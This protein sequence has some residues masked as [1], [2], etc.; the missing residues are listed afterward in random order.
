MREG[1]RWLLKL[2][3]SRLK[4]ENLPLISLVTDLLMVGNV[5]DSLEGKAIQ[6]VKQ[7]IENSPIIAFMEQ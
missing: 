2:K 3:R 4:F 7:Q 1:C 6:Q 5:D